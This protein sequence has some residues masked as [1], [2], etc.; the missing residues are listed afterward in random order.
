MEPRHIDGMVEIEEQCFNSG[1][2]QKTFL[3]ELENKIAR[4]IVAETDGKVSGYGGIWN[5]CGEAEVIDIA[6][7]I[8]FRRQ[9]IAQGILERLTEFC[10]EQG[11]EKINLEV[12]ESNLV[13]QRLYEKN[14]F[15][16]CG[17][18]KNYYDGNE[19]AILMTKTL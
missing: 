1:F 11:C 14:G 19:T 10:R 2:A 8:D 18:R 12:R 16:V 5:I 9:G 15:L 13:A 7:H 17:Q 3:K 6:T 4:Y